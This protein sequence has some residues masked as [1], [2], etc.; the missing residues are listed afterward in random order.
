M[1]NMST[2]TRESII[3]LASKHGFEL[4]KKSDGEDLYVKL[5]TFRHRMLKSNIH[6][7]KVTGIS[8][9][10]EISF[11]KV[12]VHPEEYNKNLESYKVGIAPAINRDTKLN[13]HAHT[14]YRGFPNTDG[15]KS[16]VAMAY[17]INDLETLDKLLEGLVKNKRE[18]ASSKL[19]ERA[20]SN[21]DEAKDTKTPSNKK[22][23]AK[24]LIIDTPWIDLI[25]AGEKVWEMR[26]RNC[27]IRGRIGLIRKGSGQ[28]VGTA[29]LDDCLGPF[30]E[31]ELNHQR[32]KHAITEVRMADEIWMSKWNHAWVL[33]NVEA[34][35][36]PVSYKHPNGAVTWVNVGE[37]G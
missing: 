17:Q 2:A 11:L 8:K 19:V 5:L 34:L 22:L 26:S 36:E 30:S 32:D 24:A 4:V 3:K 16:P 20:V 28:V 37:Q 33:K 9:A 29:D 6:L 7:D 23:P 1:F 13:L 10:G 35:S 18:F 14:G 31:V 27:S 25:L 12:A 21:T 15:Y